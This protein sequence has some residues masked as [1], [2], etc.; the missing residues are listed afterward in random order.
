MWTFPLF[1]G[2]RGR[3]SLRTLLRTSSPKFTRRVQSAER[4]VRVDGF[5]GAI[6]YLYS[7]LV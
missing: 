5:S 1:A 2:G 4:A 7:V 6:M 3:A